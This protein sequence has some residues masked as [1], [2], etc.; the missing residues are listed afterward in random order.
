MRGCVRGLL[1]AGIAVCGVLG[2]QASVSAAAVYSSGCSSLGWPALCTAGELTEP[3]GVAVDNSSGASQGDVYVV[4]YSPTPE[5]L[6]FNANGGRTALAPITGPAGR[7]LQL[8]LFAAVD[9]SSGD[10]YVDDYSGGVLDKFKPTGGLEEAFGVKGQLTGLEVPTG[11][12]VQQSTG[13]LFVAVRGSEKVMQYTSA[14]V[15]LGSFKVLPDPL[16]SIAVDSTGDVYVDQEGGPVAEFPAGKRTEPITV[17]GGGA[18]AVAVD[19]STGKVFVSESGG[20]EI[21][22]LQPDGTLI[23]M[24]AGGGELGAQG[25]YGIA[26]NETTHTVYASNRAEGSGGIFTLGTPRFALSIEKTG[27]NTGAGEVVSTP[28]GIAC[29]AHCRASFGE[30]TKVKLKQTAGAGSVFKGW[31]GCE[32]EP[33]GECEITIS[34]AETVKATFDETPAPPLVESESSMAVTSTTAMLAGSVNPKNETPTLCAFHYA[35]AEALLA[36]GPGVAECVPHAAEL[37]SGNTDV[38]VEASLAGLVPNTTYYYRLA[39][40]NGL[41]K[42]EGPVPA[43]QFLTLPNPPS[44][45]TG[46]ASPVTPYTAVISA[47]VNPSAQGHPAQ[48]DTTYYFQYSTDESFS[49]QTPLTPANVGEGTTPVTVQASLEGLEP[50][51]TYHYRILATNNLDTTPQLA[52]GA[53]QAFRTVVTPPILTEPAANG[54]AQSTATI[55][56]TLNPQGLPTR[57]ELSLG[58][59]PGML[60]SVAAGHTSTSEPQSLAIALASLQSGVTYYYELSAQ[61]AGGSTETPVLAFTTAPPA[62]AAPQTGGLA[63]GFPLLAVPANVFP[64]ET[65]AAPTVVVRSLT[66]RQKLTK[67]L[68]ACHKKHNRQRRTLCEHQAHNRYTPSHKRH[69]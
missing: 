4:V 25:S 18:D 37:G 69:H 63:P 11:V 22:E 49:N 2:G 40:A 58:T 5:V 10:V 59:A 52:T 66:N 68:T 39:A 30:G 56:A 6:Q 26:V 3:I 1:V 45:Q 35:V 64:A 13:D 43:Q 48:D 60:Q 61:N 15:L 20:Q 54:V 50:N 27:T 47:T 19:Q 24:F 51:T 21:A 55:D 14:G 38:G 65:P 46:E 36:S 23:E 29:G 41:G 33:G 12:A 32:A 34:A 28:V 67:A 53:T 9:S 57:W 8:P 16:D 62:P 44:V 7:E 17:V 42:S 31:E